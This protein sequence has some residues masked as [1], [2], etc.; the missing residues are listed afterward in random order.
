MA[1]RRHIVAVRNTTKDALAEAFAALQKSEI[2]E[3]NGWCFAM[4]SV[5]TTGARDIL[6]R[7]T[8]FEGPAFL[9]TTEDGC[10]WWLHLH[11]AGRER[12]STFHEFIQ[13]GVS[14]DSECGYDDWADIY[15]GEGED[16]PNVIE[17]G[18][19][20]LPAQRLTPLDF[21]DDFFEPYSDLEDDDE[22]DDE[23]ED[24]DESPISALLS[25][26]ED[27]GAPLPD[28]LVEALNS[29][30]AGEIT[31]TF[32]NLHGAYIAD[33][34]DEFHVPHVREEVLRILTGESVTSGELESDV[35]NLWRFLVHL[36]LG[37]KFEE[38]LHELERASEKAPY[39]PAAEIRR[40]VSK[41]PLYPLEDGPAFVAIEKGALLC[42]IASALDTFADFSFEI[43]ID[44]NGASWPKERIPSYTRLF[45]SP[46]GLA[47]TFDGPNVVYARRARQRIGRLLAELPD[48]I[49][50]ELAASCEKQSYRFRGAIKSGSWCIE[51]A[52]VPLSAQEVAELVELFERAEACLPQQATDEAEAAAITAAAATD[53]TLYN[54]L[55]TRDGLS[56]A[57]RS[58]EGASALAGLIFRQRFRFRWD[59]SAIEARMEE[60][61]RNWAKI[62]S[63]MAEQSALPT[64]GKV[65]YSGTASRFLEPDYTAA[66]VDEMLREKATSTDALD[67]AFAA[68]GFSHLGVLVC[69]AMGGGFLRCYA[70]DEERT[71]A[72]A[73]FLPFGQCW[74]DFVSLMDDGTVFTTTSSAMESSIRTLR[75]LIRLS[76]DTDLAAMHQNHKDGL[77]RLKEREMSP[78]AIDASLKGIART[79]DD[80]LVRRL[81]AEGEDDG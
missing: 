29:A 11:C 10:R 41:L 7:L 46:D 6:E 75:I 4:A 27:C 38:A 36:G 19:P 63:D 48:G 77:S 62:E 12:F 21:E 20:P 68:E 23:N 57:A 40:S 37:N 74:H 28:S 76:R 65:V 1:F 72:V 5:W 71:Y 8:P 42:R 17:I 26:Y 81:G 39:D 53:I 59:V 54:A 9:V 64:N 79:M 33:A 22:F 52:S 15:S 47:L 25:N 16:E 32:V 43:G 24:A 56:L 50:L 49:G 61:Y 80:F 2:E 66:S 67:G 70:N 3:A 73:Y 60:N 35:G 34:L 45:P 58:G 31:R 13:V 18:S 51:E 78:L 30:E 55:P 14:S 44:A 69:E